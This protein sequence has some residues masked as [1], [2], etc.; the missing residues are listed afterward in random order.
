MKK[1]NCEISCK[2]T[3]QMKC[4]SHCTK[5]AVIIGQDIRFGCEKDPITGNITDDELNFLN[6][7]FWDL[8]IKEQ[9]S[10]CDLG[11]KQNKNEN[12]KKVEKQKDN[13]KDI[14]GAFGPMLNFSGKTQEEIA[15]LKSKLNSGQFNQTNLSEIV[16]ITSY[17]KSVL[18]GVVS[19]RQV[20]LAEFNKIKEFITN[21]YGNNK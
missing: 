11:C 3:S 15:D 2:K 20:D 10:V 16:N 9:C 5:E 1:F 4:S 13:L 12:Y 19:G 14:L 7:K 21:K 17:A 18:D 8:G 6:C